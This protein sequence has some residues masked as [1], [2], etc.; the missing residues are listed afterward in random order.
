M[1]NYFLTATGL[2]FIILFRYFLVAGFFYWLLWVKRPE[3]FCQRKLN[4]DD[5]SPATIKSEIKWSLLTSVV[6]ALPGAVMIESW[7]AGG[8]MIYSDFEKYGVLYLL[9]SAFIYLFLHDTF[10]YWTHRLMHHPRLFRIFHQV[11]HNSR[12]PT[13]WASFSFSAWEALIEALVVPLLTFVLPIHIGVLGIIL[14]TMTLFGV[15]NHAGFEI[16]PVRWMRGF[17]GRT[18][19][20]ATHHNLHH[21]NYQVNY[22]LYFRFWDKIMGS[23]RL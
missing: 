13:P 7:K 17:W 3:H 20:T 12:S 4:M 18:M 8:T 2:Y 22:G 9:V 19:I 23:D 11:H 1:Q 5:P 15:T 21:R 16:F 6:F 14:T 10:F